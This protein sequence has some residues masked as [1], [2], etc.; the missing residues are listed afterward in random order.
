MPVMVAAATAHPADLQVLGVCKVETFG[1]DV[2]SKQ[3]VRPIA[4]A[5]YPAH[6]AHFRQDMQLTYPLA[7]ADTGDNSKAYAIAGVPTLVIVDRQGIVRYMSCG[8]G[9]PGLFQL[10]LDGVLAAK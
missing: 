2:C 8:A 4:P 3:A 9:E 5:D 10:A 7:V 6:V 1:Y